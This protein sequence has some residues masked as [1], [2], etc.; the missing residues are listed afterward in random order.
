[1]SHP[2]LGR[3][4]RRAA[5]V[6]AAGLVALAGLPAADVA[7]ADVPAPVIHYTFDDAGGST[8]TDES[9]NGH[10]GTVRREGA[11]LRDG[12][13]A[14]PGGSASSAPYVEV[15]TAALVG[16][17]DLTIST[18]LA[19]RS[20]PSNVAAAFIGA[21]VASGATHSAGYWLLN[22]SNPSGY[23]KSVVTNSV[24]P[25]APW[26]TEVGP[27]ATNAATSGAR[28]PA[29]GAL[30]T[31]VVDG[32]RG[33]LTVY[34][35][36]APIREVS[37]ARDVASFGEQLVAYIGR[38]TYDDPGWDGDVLDYAVYDTA[39]D[40]GQVGE[41]FAREALDLAVGAVE[42]PTT[43][44]ASFP[45]PGASYGARLSWA[46]DHPAITVDGATATVTRPA[47]GA[48]DATVTLTATFTV[49]EST[50]TESYSVLVP[51]DLTDEE[52]AATD[53]AAITVPGA[54]NVRTNLS[55]P[56]SGDLGSSIGWTVREGEE[57]VSFRD[58]VSAGSRTV[59]VQRPAA[60]AE[61]VE[62]VLT[63]TARS[64][65]VTRSRDLTLTLQ[66][67]PGGSAG[68]EAY[69]WA[70]FTG[71]GAGAERVSLAASRGNDALAWNT[72]NDGEPL[73]TSELGT[74]GLRDPFIIRSPEGDRFFMIATDLKI[75]GL[76]GGFRT[77]QIS[78]SL[79]MEVWESDDLVTWSDQRHVQ[80]S[81]EYAGNTWA[82]EAFWS[83]ELDTY[84]VFW[85]SNLY[86]TT[87][88]ADRTD[89]TYNRMMYA[90]TDDFVTFSEPQVWV[91]VRRGAGRG[92]IDSTVAL[93]D[94]TYHRFTKDE[95]D[96][97]IR[98]EVS[99]DLLATVSG[100][101][102]G[103]T[104]PAEEWTLVQERVA[105]GLPNGE[106]GRTFTSGEGASVFP[107]NEGDVNGLDWFLFIDQ[108]SYHGG[109]NHYIPFGTDDLGAGAWQPL[110]HLLREN[111]P[112]NS[113][114]GKPRHGTVIP[115]TRAEYQR[116]LEAYAPDIAVASVGAI[117]VTTPVG[118]APELGQ[119][120]LTMADG[121]TRT[122]D[123]A[124]A[125][126]DPA[127]YAAPGTFTVRGVAQDDSRMPVE[128]TVTVL[129]APAPAVTVE[130]GTRCVVGRVVE[131]AR[132]ANPSTEPVEVGVS[133]AFG[134]R[135]VTVGPDRTVSLTFS[136]RQ[137]AVPAGV[138][139]VST[140]DGG[141][142]GA[143]YAARSCP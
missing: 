33:T 90:T 32:T 59:V 127:D 79:H 139:S 81:T 30:Y 41:L 99:T 103:R 100:S 134:T 117:D 7:A 113:D 65:D 88:P 21:P 105:T 11:Q 27:G 111:L 53:L 15:P 120:A 141:T 98:H 95:A 14:L 20:G 102:P 80:V 87:D 112:Q 16:R 50:R 101:L 132:V 8:V 6:A 110:G 35:N 135:T 17:K 126:V 66:P 44:T 75:D 5:A 18:W 56:T 125:P 37:I 68:T 57:H 93:V 123:V 85:A 60:G 36:G 46:S 115:V 49:G 24:A 130:A 63:A 67:M 39:L 28:T 34:V 31:S 114:G 1:M 108:P 51:Q 78:G 69:V 92:M 25:S 104:G 124:W 94:G 2:T 122:V 131:T 22:P 83:E 143:A 29:G 133:S 19:P 136:T 62:V 38:S 96:M 23:V 142:V 70:F 64:G 45:L 89:V 128:A 55:V 13:L 116:V 140:A 9:G 137:Q 71:E 48:G 4:L 84:V 77:A 119:A 86:D 58:G 74:G 76:P 106:T 61:A 109:P 26:G 82:P 43:A 40:A 10:H 47:P 52:K 129:A 54:A 42:V 121:S 91:D 73:F 97:T 3:T 12:L 118:T 138:V 107:A 72:L